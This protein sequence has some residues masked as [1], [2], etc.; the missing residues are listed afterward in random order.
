MTT[1]TP[2]E[3]DDATPIEVDDA[4][5]LLLGG[6][7][8]TP[9]TRDRIE[10]VTR[11]EKLVFLLERESLVGRYLTEKPEFSS[12]NFGPFSEKVYR[13]V[14]TL[15][16]ADLVADSAKASTTSEDS[17]EAEQIIGA[18]EDRYATRDFE[19]TARGKR[20]YNALLSELPAGTSDELAEFK[21][22][23]AALPLRQL[24]R[25]VYLK[26]PEFTDKSL[27]RNDILGH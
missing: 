3:V 23:F 27:I 6:P 2:I 12:H 11:L 13:A 16:A 20:Y 1:T 8:P 17:W 21:R 10:G 4:V 19:L 24:I 25:Y 9:V 5:I 7:A 18:D 26:Y 15:A 14:D 22:R